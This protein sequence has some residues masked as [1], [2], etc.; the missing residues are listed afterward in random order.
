[1]VDPFHTPRDG[2]IFVQLTVTITNNGESTLALA[3]FDFR[4]MTADGSSYNHAELYDDA[5]PA[6][7]TAGST[8]T[9]SITFEVPTD[10]T[11]TKLSYH[12]MFTSDSV[13]AAIGAVGPPVV[14][15][16][17][18]VNNVTDLPV[19]E[20][21]GTRVVLVNFDMANEYDEPLELT[22]SA[23]RLLTSCGDTFV[24]SENATAEPMGVLAAGATRSFCVGFEIPAL[25]S[26]EA[27]IFES[28]G[29]ELEAPVP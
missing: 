13:E 8:A 23:F 17:V 1:M 24:Y 25:D 12:T 27:L 6:T 29:V 3:P 14:R 22:P 4:V 5:V 26:P 7:L 15:V 11:P 10:K 21:A 19:N 16:S 2:N 9:F 28:G 20:V 18:A